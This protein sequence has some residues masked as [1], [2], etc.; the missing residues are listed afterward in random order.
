VVRVRKLMKSSKG[1]V[2]IEYLL[3]TLFAILFSTVVGLSL[4]NFRKVS[5]LVK[6]ELEKAREHFLLVAFVK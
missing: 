5:F 6:G 4:L 3:L 1:Q 2:S